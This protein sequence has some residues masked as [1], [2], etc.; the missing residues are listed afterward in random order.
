MSF[1]S[2][3]VLYGILLFLILQATQSQ[4][5]PAQESS[6]Q[7]ILSSLRPGPHRTVYPLVEINTKTWAY[8]I[9]DFE[10][11]AYNII[12]DACYYISISETQCS[13]HPTSCQGTRLSSENFKKSV[14]KAFQTVYTF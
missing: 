8:N 1:N 13:E 3:N 9:G 14:E 4:A 11:E 10:Q 5:S 2:P 7:D 12:A 6:P